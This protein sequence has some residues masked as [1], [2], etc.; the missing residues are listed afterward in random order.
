[1]RAPSVYSPIG[2]YKLNDIDPAYLKHVL[3]HIDDYPV[4]RIH[5]LLP[6]NIPGLRPPP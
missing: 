5:E 4:N 1:M 2:S 3:T 6:W